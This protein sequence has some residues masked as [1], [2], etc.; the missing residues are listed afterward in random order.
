MSLF[1]T[2]LPSISE[3]SLQP[4]EHEGLQ[5]TQAGYEGVLLI[6]RRRLM[7]TWEA[8][9]SP[10]KAIL[11]VLADIRRH[12]TPSHLLLQRRVASQQSLSGL[13]MDFAAF[14]PW[15]L[16]QQSHLCPLRRHPLFG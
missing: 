13:N 7:S 6:M 10:K 8:E 1:V 15:S 3:L 11:D 2:Q 12:P 16:S 9:A 14:W 4:L 5:Q